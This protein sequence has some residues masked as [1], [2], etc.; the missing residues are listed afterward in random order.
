MP[1]AY[2]SL[3]SNVGDRMAHLRTAIRRLCTPDTD[4]DRVSSVYESQHVGDGGPDVPC[5]LNC[6]VALETTLEPIRLLDHALRV[7]A[8]GGRQRLHAHSPRTIDIDLL[9]YDQITMQTERLVLPHPRLWDRAFV[10]LPLSELEPSLALPDGRSIAARASSAEITAQRITL[11]SG[12][13]T[14]DGAPAAPDAG[15]ER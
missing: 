15:R 2:L 10:L 5:Y 14:A 13:I 3:G 12:G 1:T 6:V 11:W 7:E 4:I 8:L 9:A